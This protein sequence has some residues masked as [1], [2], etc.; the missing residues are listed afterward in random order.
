M[1]LR[2]YDHESPSCGLIFE[3]II[4]IET[5]IIPCKACGKG[6]KRVIGVSGCYTANDMTGWLPSVLAVV[7]KESSKPHVREFLKDP[8]RQNY[9]KWMKGEGIRPFEPGEERGKSMKDRE[10][11]LTKL[12]KEVYK[13]H[14]RRNALEVR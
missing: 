5:E 12:H 13:A 4:D 6:A 3:D 7:D 11:D 2:I 9:K 14:R 8:T 1:P 10:P